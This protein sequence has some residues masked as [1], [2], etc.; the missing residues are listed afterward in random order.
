MSWNSIVTLI[1][2]AAI[3]VLLFRGVSSPGVIFSVIPI[4][5]CLIMGFGPTQINGFIGDGLKSISGT[6]F[7]MVFAVL[8][9]GMLHEA[10]VFQALIRLVIRFLGNSVVGTMWATAMIG[11]LTQLDGSGATTA[12]CTIPTMRPIYEKQKIRPEALLLVESLASG[13]LCLLP[14]APGLCEA[15]AYVGVEVYDVF[16]WLVPLFIFSIAA[17]F[18][19]CIPLAMFEKRR[20]AGMSPEEFEQMKLE[21]HKPLAFPLGKGVAIFDGIVT[22][23]LMASLLGGWV[24]TNFAFGL[25]YGILLIANFRDI[26]KQ[27]D[28]VKKQAP[29]ALEL[30]FTMLGVGVLVGVNQGTGAM[31]ELASW[32]V[33]N[34]SSG[35]LAHLPVILCLFSMPLS[36][37]IGG[38]KNSVV[39]P[40]I[41]PM[42]ASFGFAPVQVLGAVFATG[43]I[44]ANLSLFN[45]APY[46]ALGLAGVEMK[47]HLKYSLLPVYGFSLLMI[48][49]L[50]VTGMLPL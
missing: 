25:A 41:I 30:A 16:L 5:A 31:G 43:V 18:V 28:Y 21:L 24:K 17:L 22:L 47:D 38:S 32:I 9:F 11:V 33:A 1:M 37:T 46:L 13:V 12:L 44:S 27:R 7:L 20:G 8:Y 23:V 40:A 49:F 26:K 3:I 2:M 42:V 6:L 36:I 45:A 35:F 14:W 39:L 34:T 15:A 50:V 48:L 10:G 4:I 29:M 19:L